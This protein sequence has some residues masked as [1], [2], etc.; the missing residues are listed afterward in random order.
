MEFNMSDIEIP[1]WDS[2]TSENDIESKEK[3]N[4][5][6]NVLIFYIKYF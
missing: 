4:S 6:Y 5:P 3:A 1:I 2:V